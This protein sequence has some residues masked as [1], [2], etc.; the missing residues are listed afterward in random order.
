[1]SL[2][3]WLAEI[4][5]DDNGLVPVIAQDENTGRVMMFAYANADAVALTAQKHTAHYWTR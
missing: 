2:P 5:W 1:M 4:K 3:A